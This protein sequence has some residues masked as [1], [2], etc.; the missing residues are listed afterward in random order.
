[1]SKRK[2]SADAFGLS[3][4]DVLS[5][6]LGGVILLV[7]IVAVTLKGNDRLR[8]NKPEEERQGVD[9]TS[10]DFKRSKIT[11]KFELNVL[12]VQ[13]HFKSSPVGLQLRDATG[14]TLALVG[15][16]AGA[17]SSTDWLLTTDSIVALPAR[18]V[19]KA[20][21]VGTVAQD[22]VFVIVSREQSVLFSIGDRFELADTAR[23][24]VISR[25]P[26]KSVEVKLQNKTLK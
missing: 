14:C 3:L 12:T 24:M 1:M 9:Y 5:N 23:F 19:I 7:L 4:M 21:P 15:D 10:L 8:K 22:S 16:S 18:L 6:A 2:D 20:H 11:Q 26:E 17:T 25:T 13:I